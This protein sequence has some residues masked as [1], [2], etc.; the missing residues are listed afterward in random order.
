MKSLMFFIV[1]FLLMGKWG[2][3]LII[4]LIDKTAKKM[5]S[6]IFILSH[7]STRS[8]LNTSEIREIIVL[9]SGPTG[10]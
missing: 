5:T 4:L 6:Q 7:L 3:H 9:L 10:M 8:T 2:D 1:A